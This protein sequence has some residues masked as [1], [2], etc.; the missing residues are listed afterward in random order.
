MKRFKIKYLLSFII[1]TSFVVLIISCEKESEIALHEQVIT[2]NDNFVKTDPDPPYYIVETWIY[3]IDETF[4]CI[5]PASN[6]SI[7]IVRPKV[8]ESIIDFIEN[9]KDGDFCSNAI[10]VNENIGMLA[11]YINDDALLKRIEKGELYVKFLT[12]DRFSYILALNEMVN[13]F[14]NTNV[15]RAWKFE[16]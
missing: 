4:D 15:Y 3:Y 16:K 10:A 6:C 7:V 5:P 8:K 14:S 9:N 11:N 12:D 13:D 2:N 1:L